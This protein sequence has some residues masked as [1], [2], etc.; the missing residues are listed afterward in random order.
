MAAV[1]HNA[2]CAACGS[3]HQ[4]CFP[5]DDLI[6]SNRDYEYD[7]PTTRRTVPLPHQ[8]QSCEVVGTCPEGA[9]IIRQVKS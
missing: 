2:Y 4:L 1:L 5:D 8:A 9:V 7:C 3:N 6:F